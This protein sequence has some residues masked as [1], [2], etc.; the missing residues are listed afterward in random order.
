[1]K[2]LTARDLLQGRAVV[3]RWTGR[4]RT[5]IVCGWVMGLRWFSVVEALL[6]M[7]GR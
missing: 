6:G 1:M 4:S 2:R 3:Y 5:E 7:R